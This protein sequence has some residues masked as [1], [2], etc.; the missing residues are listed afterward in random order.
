M[1]KIAKEF[2]TKLGTNIVTEFSDGEFQPSFEENIRGRDV[3]IVQSIRKLPTV[4][5]CKKD[6]QQN[7]QC[8]IH[9]DKK[10]KAD[11]SPIRP[12]N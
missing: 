9:G 3:F 8:R 2:G 12:V 5:V 7:G 11:R 4:V 10:L 6:R 1:S